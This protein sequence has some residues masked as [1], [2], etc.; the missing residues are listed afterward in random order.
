MTF[1]VVA[2]ADED[3]EYSSGNRLTCLSHAFDNSLIQNRIVEEMELMLARQDRVQIRTSVSLTTDPA[4]FE[5]ARLAHFFDWKSLYCSWNYAGQVSWCVRVNTS[6][7]AG[8]GMSSLPFPWAYT[9]NAF[10]EASV[11]TT[12]P[13]PVHYPLTSY[14]YLHCC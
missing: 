3:C 10:H 8:F 7:L 2:A 12:C 13:L 1:A 11:S 6:R 14:S 4:K 5:F 9:H